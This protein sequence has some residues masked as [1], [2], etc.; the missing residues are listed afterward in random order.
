MI[1]KS[2]KDIVEFLEAYDINDFKQINEICKKALGKG[3]QNIMFEDDPI[4]KEVIERECPWINV[5]HVVHELTE[6]ENVRHV[7]DF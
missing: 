4:Q 3:F 1:L 5:V 6:K 7:D 2:I